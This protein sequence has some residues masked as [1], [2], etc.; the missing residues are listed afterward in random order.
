MSALPQEV[1]AAIAVLAAYANSP[2]F[3]A[4]ASGASWAEF[5]TPMRDFSALAGR[6]NRLGTAFASLNKR[7]TKVAG[8][9]TVD[10]D[11][12]CKL[13]VS[14]IG[15]DTTEADLRGLFQPFG[16]ITELSLGKHRVT[17]E[18]LGF[19]HIVYSRAEAAIEAQRQMHNYRLHYMI[20]RVEHVPPP[21]PLL[22]QPEDDAPC[23]G[24]HGGCCDC[25]RAEDEWDNHSCTSEGERGCEDCGGDPCRCCSGCFPGCS[26]CDPNFNPADPWGDGAPEEHWDDD[27]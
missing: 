12:L 4:M 1:L 23:T 15:P 25:R 11:P 13:R 3:L 21:P 2:E 7:K 10:P 17:G 5:L 9:T 16:T 14:N 24:C 19:A 20:L 18:F 26:F 22:P 6:K 27:Y 8:P